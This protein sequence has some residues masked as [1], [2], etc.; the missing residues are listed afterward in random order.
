MNTIKP[1]SAVLLFRVGLC[2]AIVPAR[3]LLGAAESFNIVLN[4]GSGLSGNP[5]AL[6][7]FSRAANRWSSYFS[8]PISINIDA[9]LASLDPGIIGSTGSVLLHFSFDTVRNALVADAADETSNSIVA[10]LPTAAQFSTL[11]PSGFS[12]NGNIL[13]T[14]ANFKALGFGGLDTTYGSRDASITFN[15]GFSF[16]YDNSDGVGAG[17]VDFETVAKH[18]IG[19]ALGFV[20]QVD[21][22][23]GAASGAVGVSTLDLFRFDST[24]GNNP[25]SSAD[26]TSKPRDLRPGGI[27]VFNDLSG[28]EYLF[29][30]GLTQG[31]GRQASHWKDNLGLGL[32]DPTLTTQEL[33]EISA[34]DLRAF[35]LIGYDLAAV[36]EPQDFAAIVGVLLLGFAGVRRFGS[37]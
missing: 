36:P 4:A 24:A 19:H 10:S 29:S 16:D 6:A 30:T 11:L 3:C 22:I 31:D 20:S 15:S 28:T 5:A 9:N 35:D 23:D 7:A 26:F 32:M 13:A 12:Y 33:V 1:S 27:Q 14:K 21:A 8:D 37:R 25:S 17:L 34:L 18:E 2:L